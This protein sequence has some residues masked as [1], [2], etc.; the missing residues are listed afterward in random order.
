MNEFVEVILGGTILIP[1]ATAY[2]GLEVVQAA[3]AGGSGFSLGFLTLPTLFNNWGWFAP[4]AGAMWFG[5]LFFA[6]ITSS[7][8]MGQPIVAFLEDELK[9][10][11]TRAA[12][13]FGAA[14]LVLGFVCVWLY[15]GGAFD[16]FDFWSG[17]FALVAFA[18][19]E[20]IIFSWIFGIERGW[21]EITRGADMRVPGSFRYIIKYVTPLFILV[22]F[23]GALI[24]PAGR[25]GAAVG[26][27][28]SGQ[29]WPFSPTS[30][31]GRVLHV[32]EDY[33]WL[34]ESGELTRAFV[35]D[36][37]RVLLTCVFFAFAFLVWKAWRN[38]EP[39]DA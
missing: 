11:H 39:R 6:G 18:L 19:G 37:T 34:D 8:A 1:I 10:R 33:R 2:L 14:T 24:E 38:K 25:W 22:V 28:F 17:T 30:V 23:V 5:L 13:T 26:S 35:Q 29:G 27:L 20:A 32:G 7:L 16:E 9:V 31:I 21:E 12:V 3:T 4:L 15:P 36:A